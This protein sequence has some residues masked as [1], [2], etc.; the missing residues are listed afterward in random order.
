[1][2]EVEIIMKKIMATEKAVKKYQ[3]IPFAPWSDL[4]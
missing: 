4:P 3:V 2:T 1:M